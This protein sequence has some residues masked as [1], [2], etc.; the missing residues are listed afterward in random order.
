[1][2]LDAA[3]VDA[4]SQDLAEALNTELEVDAVGGLEVRRKLPADG[5]PA[6]CVTTP[7][8]TAKVAKS[9]G[10]NQLLFV[11]MVDSGA[12]GSIQIDTTWIDPEGSK[13]ASRPAIDLT[14]ATD[15]EAKSKFESAAPTL[16]PDAP[17]RPKPK[18]ITNISTHYEGGAPRHF[19]RTSLITASVGM[20]GVGMGLSLGLVTRSKYNSCDADL[21]TCNDSKRS[22]IRHYA[23]AADA[24]WVIAAGAAVATT[25]LY[26]T[27]AKAPNVVVTPSAE[28]GASVTA[29]GR[30]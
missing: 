4:L 24:G 7:S 23:L 3:R 16:L 2:N 30:F 9:V 13:S 5:L 6:D 18:T 12:G 15:A 25:M 8:C 17:V 26:L 22:S 29:F 1:V 28:G 10:A 27:S 21:N 19:T 11:V 20:V 14:A